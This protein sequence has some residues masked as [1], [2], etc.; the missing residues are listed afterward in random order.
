MLMP[1]LDPVE[2]AEVMW[3]S[4]TLWSCGLTSTMTSERDVDMLF[5]ENRHSLGRACSHSDES[6]PTTSVESH[7]PFTRNS[8]WLEHP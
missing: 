5:P 2:V 6:L 3:E 8:W 1:K 7:A 4:G